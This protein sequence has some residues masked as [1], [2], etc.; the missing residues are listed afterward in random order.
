[1]KIIRIGM[2]LIEWEFIPFYDTFNYS[3]TEKELKV[4][5]LCFSITFK[6]KGR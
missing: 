4:W 3:K 1:M 2:N 6:L 5:W